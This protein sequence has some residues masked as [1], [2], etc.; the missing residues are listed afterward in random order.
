MLIVSAQL[1]AEESVLQMAN[2][3]SLRQLSKFINKPSENLASRLVGIPSLHAVLL[4]YK[5]GNYPA[6]ILD[7]CRFLH[8]RGL[9]VGRALAK[10]RPDPP[11]QLEPEDYTKVC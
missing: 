2:F 8:R 9:E 4:S 7:L 11:Q 6:E 3:P 10:H 5:G 1:A